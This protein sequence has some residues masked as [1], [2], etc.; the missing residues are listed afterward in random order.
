MSQHQATNP[1]PAPVQAPAL[2]NPVHEERRCRNCAVLLPKTVPIDKPADCLCSPECE[3]RLLLDTHKFCSIGLELLK[4]DRRVGRMV[5]AAPHPSNLRIFGGTMSRDEYRSATTREKYT[6]TAAARETGKSETD[7]L[8]GEKE[9]PPSPRMRAPSAD[10]LDLSQSGV[11]EISPYELF[12]K[13][14]QYNNS[15]KSK[16]ATTAKASSSKSKK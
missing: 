16:K 13:K 15:L 14:M 9:S 7:D 3:K 12:L 11:T 8:E 6:G 1:A 4:I 5:V 10:E 2:R